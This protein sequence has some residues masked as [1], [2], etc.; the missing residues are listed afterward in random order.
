MQKI[1]DTDTKPTKVTPLTALGLHESGA[2]VPVFQYKGESYVLLLESAPVQTK[3]GEWWGTQTVGSDHMVMPVQDIPGGKT[4]QFDDKSYVKKYFPRDGPSALDPARVSTVD[5]PQLE[6]GIDAVIRELDEEAHATVVIPNDY[7]TRPHWI[8]DGGFTTS[9]GKRSQTVVLLLVTQCG[10]EGW[11]SMTQNMFRRKNQMAFEKYNRW[12]AEHPDAPESEH[13]KHRPEF[14]DLRFVTLESFGRAL[15]QA[16]QQ[17]LRY[18]KDK[19]T[20]PK[21]VISVMM[22]HTGC[23][24]FGV[25]RSWPVYILYRSGIWDRVKTAANTRQDSW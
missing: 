9:D 7:A 25:L 19:K 12:A 10:S 2:V 3:S 1:T 8:V 6:S 11:A 16:N 18:E 13:W 4:A 17:L 24:F 21:G 14:K 23:P 22:D 15:E 5:Y 20:Q